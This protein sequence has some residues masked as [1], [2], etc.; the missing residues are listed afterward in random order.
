MIG[1][2]RGSNTR[3]NIPGSIQH[4]TRKDMIRQDDTIP[5]NITRDKTV[6]V[7]GMNGMV[8]VRNTREDQQSDGCRS[9]GLL[10]LPTAHECIVVLLTSVGDHL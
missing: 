10:V 4:E 5:K 7:L 8:F 1:M 3:Y 6:L 2:V 9:C